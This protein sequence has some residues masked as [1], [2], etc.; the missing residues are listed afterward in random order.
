MGY[1]LRLLMLVG[2]EPDRL[3]TIEEVA[4]GFVTS[5]VRG[6]KAAAERKFGVDWPDVME[7]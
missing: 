4:G 1:A 6:I 7:Q 2:R 3:V 5:N